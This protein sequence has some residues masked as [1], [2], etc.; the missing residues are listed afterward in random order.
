MVSRIGVIR[1]R[2]L[3]ESG[4]FEEAIAFADSYFGDEEPEVEWSRLL[5]AAYLQRGFH[6]LALSSIRTA[7][8]K[9]SSS[10]VALIVQEAEIHHGYGDVRSAFEALERA[11][12]VASS[13]VHFV[14][15][16]AARLGVRIQRPESY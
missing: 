7:Q 8:R 1:M 11:A 3:V 16:C 9:S 2:L 15:R 12:S 10:D 14:E 5:A 6:L 13:Q 4:N